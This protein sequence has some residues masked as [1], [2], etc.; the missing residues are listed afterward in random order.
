[1]RKKYDIQ[2]IIGDIEP[3]IPVLATLPTITRD[4]NT[5]VTTIPTANDAC[6][7]VINATTTSP[8]SY[9][10]P[11]N[12]TIVWNYNDGNGNSSTQN[13]T[14]TITS[15]P[16]PTAN[17]PQTFCVQQNATLNEIQITGQ[18]IKWY[19]NLTNGTLV[20]P[21]TVAQDKT[22]YYASQTINGC[23][24]NRIPVTI[25]IQVTP[26]PTGN[27][28]QPFCTGQTPTIANIQVTGTTIK[29][30]DAQNNGSLL[31]ETT[32]LVNGKTYYA[33]QTVNGC[34]G[35]RFGVTISIV[36]TPPAPT[37]NANQTFC[38]S[39][40]ATLNNIQISG[41][42]IKW[43][44]TAMSASTLP[45]TTLLENNR[46]YYASQTI[47][48][49]SDRTP[50]LVRVY[51]TAM[52]TGNSSQLFCIDENATIANLNIIGTNI[53]WY[54]SSTNGALLPT[55]TLLQNQTYYA[56]QTLNNCES[57]RFA[58]SVKIQDPQNPI[59]SS[60]QTFC[61]QQ[62]A[63]ISDITISGENLKWFES[64]TSTISLSESTL[65]ENG[66][67]YYASEEINNCESGRV[68]VSIN[69]LEATAGNCINFV[70]ELPFPKFFT[71]NGDGYNDHWTIDFAYLAPNTAIR[72]F[73]R[74]GK[75]IK[76][77]SN[78]TAW[79]GNYLGQQQPASDYWFIVTR[80][81]GKEFRGHFSLK[82]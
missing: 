55:T 10:L 70:D 73:D 71:P 51:D 35:P 16:L 63:K 57:Q 68:P 41:Q 56:S 80:A 30:Y 40:N 6:A 59:A 47:G 82:R 72:I 67:T 36:N 44:D 24:S 69:V 43:F 14:V 38:K 33:S 79:D 20:S 53:K 29:W 4:C 3:P 18:N 62:K 45:N 27:T 48:C 26:A 2:V 9:A 22:T 19:S 76:E 78:G 58:V 60:P 39:E 75:F 17:S 5:T 42:N 21:T 74:Y 50:V 32:S 65:L 7:G 46:T 49:E 31:S 37:A 66:M 8:L 12:Y 28:N 13:Q 81:N 34:E 64:P 15:Q 54:N 61:V 25:N 23:E 1:M 77:L 11:G 52:P